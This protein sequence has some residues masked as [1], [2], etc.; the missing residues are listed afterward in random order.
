MLA[1]LATMYMASPVVAQK[2]TD[3]AWKKT[4]TREI[5]MS[6][7]E[8]KEH[9]LKNVGKEDLLAELLADDVLKGKIRGYANTY[10]PVWRGLTHD[11]VANTLSPK[12]D[13]TIVFDPV[14]GKD[15]Q[16]VVYYDADF[17]AMQKSRILEEWGL[18]PATGKTEIQILGIAPVREVSVDGALRGKQAVF[19]VKYADA[20]P[21]LRRY[22]QKHPT[23]PFASYIWDDYFLS[24]TKPSPLK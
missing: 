3:N 19:W 17:G 18:N 1:L 10:E 14:S 22:D 21:A 9:H 12:V 23:R 8:D 13:T 6:S 24:D 11:E 16:K 20:L 15:V 5:D 7:A 4:V 2:P